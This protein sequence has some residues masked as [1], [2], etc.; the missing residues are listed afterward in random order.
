M[1]VIFPLQ[2]GRVAALP[3]SGIP[4]Q[5]VSLESW[6]G[7]DGFRA[8]ITGIGIREGANVQYLQT[9][10]R[11]IYVYVFGDRIGDMVVSGITFSHGCDGPGAGIEAVRNYYRQNRVT[12]RVSPVSLTLGASTTFVG[13]LDRSQ[14]A[15]QDVEHRFFNFSLP[16]TQIPED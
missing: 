7:F 10:S 11:V 16:M 9:L 3:M 2:P 5:L 14:I 8:I 12:N 13:Y 6:G 15:V 1:A 4:G